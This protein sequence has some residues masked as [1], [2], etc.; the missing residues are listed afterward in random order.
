MSPVEK[1][2]DPPDEAANP[3]LNPLWNP[4]LGE[5]MGRWAE[6][7]FTSSP[8]KRQQAVR[9]LLSELQVQ[10]Q[11]RTPHGPQVAS[12]LP[13]RERA[14]TTSHP[15]SVCPACQAKNDADHKFCS[16]C[17][18]LLAAV[19]TMKISAPAVEIPPEPASPAAVR[20]EMGQLRE[21]AA[22]R[23]NAFQG[24]VRDGWKFMLI[25]LILAAGG[26]YT[27]RQWR[28]SWQKAAPA[29]RTE[30]PSDGRGAVAST[31]NNRL[32]PLPAPAPRN[33]AHPP[34]K[35]SARKMS[36]RAGPALPRVQVAERPEGRF[37]YPASPQAGL[38]GNVN[39]KVLIGTEGRVKQVVVL[40]GDHRLAE[41][42]V[43][44]VRRWRYGHHELNG[45]PA[46]AETAVSIS[47]LGADAVSIKFL[48]LNSI[49]PAEI[50]PGR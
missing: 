48:P 40:G 46:E 45:Q 23:R 42:A 14:A 30:L 31:Q 33:S 8:E 26:S 21:K 17:G 49:S 7:Y 22:V 12:D 3:E 4:V 27:Y 36:T 28:I 35:K 43:R 44:A 24:R 41:A 34:G 20:R 2:P 5:N 32:V 6:V 10:D 13:P 11:P 47:F 1:E 18:A 25:A 50:H 16:M 15:K 39:L 29:P 38:A 9:D 19:D 37:V